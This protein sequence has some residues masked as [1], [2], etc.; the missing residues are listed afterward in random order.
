MR[1]RM[2]N[3]RLIVLSASTLEELVNSA[4]ATMKVNTA[5]GLWVSD[6]GSIEFLCRLPRGA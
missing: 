4:G 2:R 6:V 3:I 1:S 5:K